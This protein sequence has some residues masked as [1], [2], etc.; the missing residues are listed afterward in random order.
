MCP[1]LN[2]VP[3]FAFVYHVLLSCF[4]S[5]FDSAAIYFNFLFSL[6]LLVHASPAQIFKLQCPSQGSNSWSFWCFCFPA[7]LMLLVLGTTSC[8]CFKA[9]PL[10]LELINFFRMR[11]AFEPEPRGLT[12]LALSIQV[13][14]DRAWVFTVCDNQFQL[15]RAKGS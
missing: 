7:V 5:Q 1:D 8:C 6:W 12:K 10:V 9:L 14:T 11:V 4:D 13:W 2:I 3:N 15:A